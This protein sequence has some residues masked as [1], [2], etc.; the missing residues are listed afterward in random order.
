MW[1]LRPIINLSANGQDTTEL[2]FY[3]PIATKYAIKIQFNGNQYKYFKYEPDISEVNYLNSKMKDEANEIIF[4]KTEN[5][6]K[7]YTQ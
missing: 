3:Y 1:R 6:L 2:D 4:A 5:E 7:N